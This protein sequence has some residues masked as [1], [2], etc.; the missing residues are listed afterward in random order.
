[1]KNKV[2]RTLAVKK[3][4]L[5]KSLF[6]ACLLAASF[7]V[8]AETMYVV[9]G[10]CNVPLK[11]GMGSASYQ[12]FTWDGTN[13]AATTDITCDV[14]GTAGSYYNSTS[15]ALSDLKNTGNYSTSSGNSKTMQAIKLAGSTK[16]TISLGSKAMSKVIVVGRANSSDQLSIDILGETVSTNN[17]DFFVIEKEQL[18]TGSVVIDNT[19]SKEYNFF[20]YLIEGEAPPAVSVTGV[21]LNKSTLT[22]EVGEEETLVPT[23]SPSDASN[24]KVSWSSNNEA[25]AT[26]DADGLVSAVAEGTATITVTTEDGG[27]TATCAVTVTAP[28]TIIEV[29]SI[30]LNKSTATVKIGNSETLT[31]TYTPSNA[32]TG[33]SVTWASD[34]N[35]IA[36]VNNGVVTGVS[37][38]VAHI[39]ATTPN[40]KSASCTVTVEA[41]A[42]VPPTTLTLHEAGVYEAKSKDG[43]YDATLSV[44]N[45]REYEV[46]YAGRWDNGGTKLTIHAN[47]VDKSQG[48]TKNETN[49]SYEAIDGWFKG[50][51]ADKGTGFAANEEFSKASERCHTLKSTNSIEMHIK[52]F[53]QFSLYGMD[54]KV[55]TS[56]P[57][58]NKVFKILIDD[59]A[60]DM[61]ISTSAT[62]R[63]FSITTGEH[64]IKIQCDDDCLFGG[65]SLR[66][67][68]EPKT[69]YL[70]GNDSTQTVLATTDLKPIYYYTKYNS[71]G[72]TKLV[73]DGEEATGITLTTKNT[74]GIGDTLVVSGTA[75]C[76][77]GEYNYHVS[78]LFNGIETRR[79]NGKFIVEHQIKALTD[80][81]VEAYAGE[82]MDAMRFRCY[83]SN[84]LL[85]FTYDTWPEGIEW[86]YNKQTGI[87]TLS[88]TPTQAGEYD[89]LVEAKLGNSIKCKIIVKPLDLGNDPILYLYKNIGAYTKD[90]VFNYLTSSGKNLIARKTKEDGLRPTDQYAKYKWILISEDANA[91]NA[92][93][94]AIA[95]GET[96]LP[97]LNMKGFSYSPDRLEWGEPDNGSLDT[98]TDN[99]YNIFVQRADHPIFQKLGW[100]QGQKVKV[101]SKVEHKGLMPVNV[102][103]QGTLCLATAYTRNIKDYYKD[104]ELQ[105]ILHEVPA[106]LRN[107]H[108]Y[109]CLPIAANATL[110]TE[111]KNLLNAAIDYLLGNEST[112]SIPTLKI[113]DF[114]VDGE[115][116]EIDDLNNTISLELDMQKHA[117]L[118][119]KALKPTVSV[120]DPTLTH[121]L[122]AANEA[123]DFSESL[124]IPV[125][126]V[127][128][129]YINRREYDVKIKALNA[130]GIED[131]YA[132]GEWV[133]IYDIYGRIVATT[134]ENI[135]QMDLPTGMYLVVTTDGRTI[136]IMK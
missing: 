5:K 37:E 42:P 69:K 13:A 104:G 15:L 128:T 71:K 50:T 122:P 64:V 60:Q 79:V 119:I 67:A 9:S 118:N 10:K 47:P 120:A 108:K 114:T 1:M 111:G 20:I 45:G 75:N 33:K 49:T 95:R 106:D 124:N 25:A 32:N 81:I 30:S 87:V 22:L 129:D 117:N 3:S 115:K 16:M 26:V 91:D 52:G 96:S 123:I 8:T 73:W 125:V 38:G 51:G 53:D 85:R 127:V 29:E 55:D 27:K 94:L 126:Y 48:V 103:Y 12:I 4:I 56:K 17:K 101:L 88:G 24:K 21:S 11:A 133:N 54:K 105:T 78:S 100:T 130:Q 19:T 44:L 97:V 112:V 92:E 134:N 23:V 86:A 39:T 121:V 65:F 135:Y 116:A 82:E 98:V 83:I 131:I 2:N 74:D 6:L 72:E 110:T 63:R 89:I 109:I 35:G 77:A 58:N 132:N 34:A 14:T 18:F 99:R 76:P 70:K 107:G 57:T 68:Q 136:K 62:I 61:E 113:T 93:V 66:V 40:G 36:T 102:D 43:G 46:Y 84:D 59:V 28:S 7:S 41:A 90:Q 31:V 80:T